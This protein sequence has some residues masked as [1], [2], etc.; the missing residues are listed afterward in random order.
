[1]RIS[2]ITNWAYGVTV[3]LTVLSGGAFILSARS[4]EQERR[5]VEEHLAL[6]ELGEELA[7][8]AEERSDEAR[9][10]VMRGEDRHLQAFR[11]R[12]NEERRHEAAIRGV[13]ALEASPAELSALEEVEAESEALDKIELAAISAYQAGDRAGAQTAL[14]GPD[15]ERQQTALLEAVTRFRE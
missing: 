6:D 13:R 9:L 4:A 10:F 12:E 7:L 2:T 8:G 14:F 3:F 5:A 1:M 15:H 11:G